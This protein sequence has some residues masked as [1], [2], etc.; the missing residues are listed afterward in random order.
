MRS[1]IFYS[2]KRITAKE[3]DSLAAK[4]AKPSPTSETSTDEEKT[5]PRRGGKK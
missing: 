4:L 5:Q 1:K 2:G 3:A